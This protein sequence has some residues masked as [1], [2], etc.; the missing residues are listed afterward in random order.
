MLQVW[1]ISFVFLALIAWNAHALAGSESKNC[2]IIERDAPPAETSRSLSSS[3]TA[4]NGQVSA[5]STGGNTVTMHS[6]DG[7]VSSSI[8]TTG[9]GGQTV[10]TNSDGTCTIYR[11]KEK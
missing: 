7:S 8:S 5:H 4:G 10:V 11:N 2:K 3:V 6:G 9:S 1:R